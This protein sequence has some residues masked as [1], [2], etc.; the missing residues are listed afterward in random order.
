MKTT[1]AGIRNIPLTFKMILDPVP[2][3]SEGKPDV[4]DL[5]QDVRTAEP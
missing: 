3:H 2:H 5:D 4:S 1:E